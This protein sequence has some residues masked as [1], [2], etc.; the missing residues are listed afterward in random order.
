V[1]EE[2]LDLNKYSMTLVYKKVDVKVTRLTVRKV[3]GRNT[4]LNGLYCTYGAHLRT[5]LDK[6]TRLRGESDSLRS[7]E[8]KFS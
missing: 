7:C 1:I 5:K 6:I 4:G 2:M 8:L 3:L